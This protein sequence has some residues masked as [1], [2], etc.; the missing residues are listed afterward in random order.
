[1]LLL[2]NLII[3]IRVE[4]VVFGIRLSDAYQ[5]YFSMCLDIRWLLLDARYK[6]SGKLI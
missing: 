1:M 5:C 6:W 2:D 3:M 4:I